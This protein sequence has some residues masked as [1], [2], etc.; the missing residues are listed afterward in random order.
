MFSRFRLFDLRCN[1]LCYF[2]G[3]NKISKALTCTRYRHNQKAKHIVCSM[4]I[5]IECWILLLV[6]TIKY[7]SRLYNVPNE[8]QF[9][10]H[11]SF[12]FIGN[13]VKFSCANSTARNTLIAKK[14]HC[15]QLFSLFTHPLKRWNGSKLIFF[16]YICNKN[17]KIVLPLNQF[18]KIFWCW[19][20]EK[21]FIASLRAYITIFVSYWNFAI[22]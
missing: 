22:V 21:I 4:F 13:K 10:F 15:V 16:S 19:W 9:Q 5:F 12:H 14:Y 3:I 6:F 7:F 8:S 11:I 17:E 2:N 1:I 18:W 20:C